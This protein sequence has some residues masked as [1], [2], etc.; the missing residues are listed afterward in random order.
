MDDNAVSANNEDVG[1]ALT[2]ICSPLFRSK[3]STGTPGQQGCM[4]VADAYEE[5]IEAALIQYAGQSML[6]LAVRAR[7]R[8]ALLS[9]PFPA[10]LEATVVP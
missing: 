2:F 6:S 3:W 10:N 4:L 7:R 1:L 8:S 5:S 9:C